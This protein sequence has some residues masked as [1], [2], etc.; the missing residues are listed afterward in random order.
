MLGNEGHSFPIFGLSVVGTEKANT[1]I[2]VSNNGR[3]CVWAME[4]L[5]SPEK[6][7]DL[8]Y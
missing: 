8:K 4:M 5:A 3:L 2:S 1:I 7:I 6:S